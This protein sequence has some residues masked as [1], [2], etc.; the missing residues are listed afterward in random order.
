M[1]AIQH[2]KS[3]HLLPLSS[4]IFSPKSAFNLRSNNQ[5]NIN[6]KSTTTLAITEEPD[7]EI[8]AL[9][10]A[11]AQSLRRQSKNDDLSKRSIHVH[12]SIETEVRHVKSLIN[13][14]GGKKKKK[15]SIWRRFVNVLKKRFHKKEAP[16][17]APT[18]APV[19]VAKPLIISSPTD[20]QHLR[21]GVACLAAANVPK[22]SDDIEDWETICALSRWG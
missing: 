16:T 5:R 20:F 15:K 10:S 14:E 21:S 18:P 11:P 12:T 7:D 4:M 22:G 17:P 6:S 9:P 2:H 19:P 3:R 8:T 1:P 13:L